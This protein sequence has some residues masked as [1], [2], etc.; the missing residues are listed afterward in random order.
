MTSDD[1]MREVLANTVLIFLVLSV[2]YLVGDVALRTLKEIK[3]RRQQ[4]ERD[5]Q[6]FYELTEKDRKLHD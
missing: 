6:R 1:V 5:R 4:Y 3:E 2:T